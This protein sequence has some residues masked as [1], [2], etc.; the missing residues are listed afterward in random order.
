MNPTYLLISLKLRI[1][2]NFT[3]INIRRTL[4]IV[5]LLLLAISFLACSSSGGDSENEVSESY[6]YQAPL[7]SGDGW[8]TNNLTQLG[9]DP[10]LLETL[11]NNIK[12]NRSGFLHIDSLLIA[13]NGELLLHE[14]LRTSLD[15]ADG[16]ADNTN[17]DLHVLNSVTKSYTSALIGIAID[18][19]LISGVDV[20]VHDYFSHKLP[21]AD[22]SEAKQNITLENWLNM[23]HG[24]SW[25]EWNVSYLDSSNLNS[26]MNNASDPIQFLLDR[27]MSSEPGTIFAYSTGVT[28]GIGRLLQLATGM[29]VEVFLRDNLLTPLN[30]S[31]Y[32]FW[33]LEGQL[34]TGSALYLKTRDMAKF[35]Q[36]FLDG[37]V[38]NGRRI[39]SEQWIEASTQQRVNLNESGSSGYGYQWWMSEFQSDGQNYRSYYANGYGGQFIFVFPELQLVIAMTGSAY[40]EG[41]DEERSIRGILQN[42]ILPIF[43]RGQ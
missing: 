36:L 29:S 7:Q 39:I 15:F 14:Q 1:K 10:T 34:H 2:E 42:N 38:W 22:W 5:I 30:I 26:Q 41:Q 40:Q 35:G 9:L 16:W 11:I 17:I 43:S 27:P 28:F 21:I 32:D 12:N 25:D 13:Q 4:E 23:R 24:Y 20:K 18:Q 31:D 6:T 19:Q 8:K 3:M 33:S 37:G